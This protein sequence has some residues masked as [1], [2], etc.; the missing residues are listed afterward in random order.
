[1]GN[2]AGILNCNISFND[3]YTKSTYWT[4]KIYKKL[5]ETAFGT[6]CKELNIHLAMVICNN[7]ACLGLPVM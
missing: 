3:S 2:S 7:S 4:Q 1:M 6:N 5:I